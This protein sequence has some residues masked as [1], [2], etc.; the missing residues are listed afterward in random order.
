MAAKDVNYANTF[1]NV[2][3]ALLYTQA[4][5]LAHIDMV[6]PNPSECYKVNTIHYSLSGWQTLLGLDAFIHWEEI[7]KALGCSSQWWIFFLPLMTV[8]EM[9]VPQLF[10]I[11]WKNK[12]YL[13]DGSRRDGSENSW[14][15]AVLLEYITVSAIISLKLFSLDS[16]TKTV[17]VLANFGVRADS[18]NRARTF[19]VFGFPKNWGQM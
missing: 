2:R 16:S 17:D 13:G 3:T 18:W 7:G 19:R 1:K 14:S 10:K 4:P 11:L 8:E 12:P 5:T 15:I 6:W 9:K